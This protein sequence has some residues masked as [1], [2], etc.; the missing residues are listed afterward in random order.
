MGLR[1]VRIHA[2]GDG[3]VGQYFDRHGYGD[4]SR[5]LRAV[6]SL[7][8]DLRPVSLHLVIGAWQTSPRGVQWLS[9]TT[10]S[11]TIELNGDLEGFLLRLCRREYE[12]SCHSSGDHR[13]GRHY[14]CGRI[15]IAVRNRTG[16]K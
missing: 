14:K 3:F 5:P 10:Q 9:K 12:P 1:H 13:K 16:R 6:A 2:Y 4:L 8:G 11:L 7:G 15:A